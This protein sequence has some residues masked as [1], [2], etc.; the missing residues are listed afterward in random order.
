[1]SIQIEAYENSQALKD[2]DAYFSAEE[3]LVV[4]LIDP[5]LT[6]TY[7]PPD[8]AVNI[9]LKKMIRDEYCNNF[10]KLFSTLKQ[11]ANIQARDKISSILRRP[12]GIYE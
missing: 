7:Q 1:M 3:E 9:P 5:C 10:A 8:I 4:E 11:S 2:I 6:F 12:C